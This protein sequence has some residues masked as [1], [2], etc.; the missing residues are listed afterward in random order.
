MS[1]KKYRIVT[2]KS[3]EKKFKKLIGKNKQIEN[4]F[5]AKLEKLRQ[6]PKDPILKFHKVN[7]SKFGEVLSSSITGD[8]RLI[9]KYDE[10]DNIILILLDIGGHDA[11]YS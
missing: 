1:D 10:N 5:Y 8:I 4:Y 7:T 6:D 11:V 9:W 2:L 3:F